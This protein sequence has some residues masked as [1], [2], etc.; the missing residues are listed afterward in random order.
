MSAAHGAA[1]AYGNRHLLLRA[2]LA[3]LL[4]VLCLL[5][6]IVSP[7]ALLE[8]QSSG[9]SGRG[10]PAGAR[11]FLRMYSD[12]AAVYGINAFL[13][14]AV[15]EDET[16]YGRS[17]LP[18]VR[19]G[20]NSAGCCAG[21]MQF[22][23]GGGASPVAGGRGMTWA[24]YRDAYRS[25]RLARPGS[26]PNRFTRPEHARPNVYD[27]YDSIY[28]AAKYFRGLGAGRRLD[29]RSFQALVRYKGTPPASIPFARRDYERA[30][31]LEQLAAAGPGGGVDAGPVPVVPGSR[32]R[33]LPNG[34]AAAPANA[35]RAVRGMIAAGNRISNKPYLLFHYPTHIGNPTYDCSS[36]SS[37]VLWGG[38]VF[39]R[40][41]WVSGQF[42]R[43]GSPGHGR[44]ASVYA[45]SGHMFLY[46]AGLRF[47]TGR[48]D[49]GP[50][51]GE[52]GPRWRAGPRPLSGFVV[53]H[54]SGL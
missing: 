46:V 22:Y 14:M 47:D 5:L 52:S 54:P 8:Q 20:V 39:G 1:V 3:A 34:L 17:A 6:L 31:E 48:Y 4:A 19:S 25:A 32:A 53:R 24:G 30:R 2:A 35:P 45:N 9:I 50:N 12:A 27:S 38:G 7:V 43:Y 29:Q 36:S 41:P 15:H 18:G 51:A 49:S 11:P 33:V 28:A 44:W 13:L 21:P 23:I 26:Y 37:H 10:L 16:N 40:A 42:M